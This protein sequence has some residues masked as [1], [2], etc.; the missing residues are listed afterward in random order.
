[1][2]DAL[3]LG[4]SNFR[5][6]NRARGGCVVASFIDKSRNIWHIV[7][8]RQIWAAMFKQ[9]ESM[10]APLLYT[11]LTTGD[12]SSPGGSFYFFRCNPLKSQDSAKGSQ[13][14]PSIFPRFSLDLLAARSRP[15]CAIGP[16]GANSSRGGG[17]TAIGSPGVSL[18]AL[19]QPPIVAASRLA[20]VSKR[21]Q[22][23][24]QRTPPASAGSNPSGGYH[25]RHSP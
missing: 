8:Q 13:G 23:S 9:L 1:V 25:A 4:R 21:A 19:D 3:P 12:A 7:L 24:S 14:N 20:S 11:I 6:V 18:G 10:I 16:K 15:G 5:P 22:F 17:R 2:A